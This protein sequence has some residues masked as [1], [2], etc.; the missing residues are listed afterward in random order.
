MGVA[1]D[2]LELDDE[3]DVSDRI[4]SIDEYC[5]CHTISNVQNKYM[6]ETSKGRNKQ[7][8]NQTMLET[9]NSRNKNCQ[10]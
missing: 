1:G 10:K 2:E 3:V 9:S 7:N 5:I 6:S 8:Q 4:Q